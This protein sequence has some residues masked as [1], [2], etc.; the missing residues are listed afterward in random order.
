MFSGTAPGQQVVSLTQVSSTSWSLV[1]KANGTGTIV[2][3]VAAGA[4]ND[5]SGNASIAESNSTTAPINFAGYSDASQSQGIA[6]PDVDHSVTYNSPLQI[7]QPTPLNLEVAEPGAQS[8]TFR[9]ENLTA[10]GNGQV[11][12]APSATVFLNQ[13][14]SD[15]VPDSSLPTPVPP[16]G[17]QVS[18]KRSQLIQISAPLSPH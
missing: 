6:G 12:K 2:P 17:Q 3:S 14:W 18:Q 4:I 15:L 16:Q 7:T 1:T 8:Q 10:N 5:V 11:E 9:V 13:V